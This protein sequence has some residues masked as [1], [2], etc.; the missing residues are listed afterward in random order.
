MSVRIYNPQSLRHGMEVAVLD[1]GRWVK[2]T[3]DGVPSF[4]WVCVAGMPG[5]AGSASVRVCRVR[6]A[7]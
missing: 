7:G 3:V 2:G 6:I 1:R 4:G 5:R